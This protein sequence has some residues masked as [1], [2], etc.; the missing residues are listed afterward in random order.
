MKFEYATG[1]LKFILGWVVVFLFRLIPFRPPNFEP[2]LATIMPVSKRFGMLGSFLFGFLGIV[3]FDAVTSGWGSWTVVTAI[4]YGVLG[5]G[6]QL[7]FRNR[8]A[9]VRNFLSFGIVGTIF[10]DAVTGLTIGPIFQGQ[11]FMVALTGQIPFTLMHLLG[12]VVFATFL[13]PALYRWVVRSETLELSVIL[14][15]FAK[16]GIK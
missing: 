14:P 3:L 9:T 12:T 5:I 13:S 15:K 1:W 11:S 6:S 16:I 4:A 8:E 2:M 7:Y 10:Y